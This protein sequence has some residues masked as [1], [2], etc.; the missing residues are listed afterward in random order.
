MKYTANDI[1][2][3]IDNVYRI[4]NIQAAAGKMIGKFWWRWAFR[5]YD[6]THIMPS[7]PEL[8]NGQNL[9]GKLPASI[10]AI[11]YYLI[12]KS[13]SGQTWNMNVLTSDLLFCFDPAE[14]AALGNLS[15]I[16]VGIDIFASKPTRPVLL[17]TVNFTNKLMKS[18]AAPANYPLQAV[19]PVNPEGDSADSEGWY[20]IQRYNLTDLAAGDA[21]YLVTEGI[22]DYGLPFYKYDLAYGGDPAVAPY[23]SGQPS[24]FVQKK[25]DLKNYWNIWQ[26]RETL[27]AD[28][29]SWHTVTGKTG[30]V[31]NSRLMLG[32][33]STSLLKAYNM[34]PIDWTAF[35]AAN[36]G[37]IGSNAYL[38]AAGN[39]PYMCF[40]ITTLVTDDG[41]VKVFDSTS[42]ETLANQ[43]ITALNVWSQVGDLTKQLVLPGTISYP[44]Y[45]ATKMEIVVNDVEGNFRLIDTITLTPSTNS[46]FSDAVPVAYT[47]SKEFVSTNP[48]SYRWRKYNITLDSLGNFTNYPLYS[49][50][51]DGQGVLIDN[52]RVIASGLTNPFTWDPANSYRIGNGKVI[53]IGANS[54]NLSAGSFGEHPIV[55]FTNEGIFGMQQGSFP[56]LFQSVSPLSGEILVSGSLLPLRDSIIFIGKR[57]V[58]MLQGKQTLVLSEIL[59]GEAFNPINGLDIYGQLLTNPLLF[60][61]Q[62]VINADTEIR[63]EFNGYLDDTTCLG[64]DN[65]RD[66]LIVFTPTKAY[67]WH[68]SFI[69]KIWY[70]DSQN[71]DSVINSWPESYVVKANTIFDLSMEDKTAAVEIMLQSNPIRLSEIGEYKG[72]DLVEMSGNITPAGVGKYSGIYLFGCEFNDNYFILG[73][74]QINS[75]ILTYRSKSYSRMKVTEIILILTSLVNYNSFILPALTITTK[76]KFNQTKS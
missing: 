12:N 46:N 56:V 31:Y 3:L 32:N 18:L 27:D 37:A 59:D 36:V 68:F 48:V 34:P 64:Y 45:R 14:F 24:P 49:M 13:A 54:E 44:D 41:T 75:Q 65:K 52:N 30:F 6:G 8:I 7:T 61:S 71:W 62:A 67:S 74:D 11:Y 63:T 9:I 72:I 51:L 60:N 40:L 25:I 42:F 38:Y 70:K 16:I 21:S 58:T 4:E 55:V 53:A 33:I 66:E 5:L 2:V 69:D 57:G 1:G 39:H 26:S 17:D 73:G 35:N 10:D 47:A 76:T 23:T 22:T 28:T 20:L 15:D 19:I 50:P 43:H 29:G